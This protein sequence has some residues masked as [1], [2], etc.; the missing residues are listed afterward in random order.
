MT[1]EELLKGAALSIGRLAY[2]G[3]PDIGP[4]GD[5]EWNP[6]EDDDDAFRLALALQLKIEYWPENDSLLCS[7]PGA[8]RATSVAAI[9]DVELRYAIVQAAAQKGLTL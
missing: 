7:L 9:G 5:Q 1:N 8:M 4:N 3:T 2:D 6:L